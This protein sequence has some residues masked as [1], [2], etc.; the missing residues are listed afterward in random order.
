MSQYTFAMCSYREKKSEPQEL[1][2]LDGY[3]VDYS[4]PQPGKNTPLHGVTVYVHTFYN[5]DYLFFNVLLSQAWMVAGLFS[6]QWRKATLWCLPV[7]MSRTASCGSRPCIVPLA[8]PTNL[9]HPLR[10]RNLTPKG[11]PQP[12]W[13]LLFLSSVSSLEHNTAAKAES[14]FHPQSSESSNP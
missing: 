7:T 5:T 2:Q 13:M 9:S 3:T 12:K 4:D 14:S 1:L 11:V 8:S 10:S 6:M